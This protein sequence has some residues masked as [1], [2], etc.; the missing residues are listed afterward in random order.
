MPDLV[1]LAYASARSQKLSVL[2]I[3]D[4]LVPIRKRN[5]ELGVSGI[6]LSVEA[7]FFQLLEGEAAIVK[8]LYDRISADKRHANILKLIE[9]PIEKR[10]FSEWSMGLARMTRAELASLPGCNDFFRSGTLLAS[11]SE[12]RARA[13]LEAFRDGAWR[14]NVS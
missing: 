6:L 12:G 13:L 9:E 5:A 1:R 11:L 4:L 8:S 7:S 14:R 10:D 2:S 3:A